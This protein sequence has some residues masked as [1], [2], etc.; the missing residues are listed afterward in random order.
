MMWLYCVNLS[1]IR[2]FFPPIA[3]SKKI[4]SVNVGRSGAIK[5]LE[6]DEP[7]SGIDANSLGS[8][9]S[10]D[11]KNSSTDRGMPK[12][13]KMDSAGSSK[14]TKD[15]KKKKKS[16]EKKTTASAVRIQVA[17]IIEKLLMTWYFNFP[18]VTRNFVV[19]KKKKNWF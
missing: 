17:K 3:I 5:N 4:E 9:S 19:F 14:N 16:K 6:V 2:F 7:D 13:R 18:K 10:N 11:Q 8:C 15:E 1:L 12:K